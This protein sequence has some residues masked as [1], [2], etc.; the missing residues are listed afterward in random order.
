VLLISITQN[1]L[2]LA[3]V[4]PFAF[5]MIIGAIILVAITL[6]NTRIEKLLPFMRQNE[7]RR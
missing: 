4:S 6:S 3:G 5:K 2:N 7:G 1:G